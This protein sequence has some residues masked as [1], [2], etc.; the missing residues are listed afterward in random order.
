MATLYASSADMYSLSRN[1]SFPYKA[2]LSATVDK[3]LY[4]SQD[5]QK[6]ADLLP[7]S[8]LQLSYSALVGSWPSFR[9]ALEAF[10]GWDRSQGIA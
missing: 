9:L 7:V 10:L 1:S 4:E 2:W 3:Q 6:Q 8:S 5:S